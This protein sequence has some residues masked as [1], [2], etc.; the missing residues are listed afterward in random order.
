MDGGGWF[1][2]LGCWVVGGGWWYRADQL[3]LLT[4]STVSLNALKGEGDCVVPS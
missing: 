1:L 3:D 4:V 2:G